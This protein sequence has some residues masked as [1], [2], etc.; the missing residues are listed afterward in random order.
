MPS[1]LIAVCGTVWLDIYIKIIV[2]CRDINHNLRKLLQFIGKN[3]IKFFILFIFLLTNTRSNL[4]YVYEILCQDLRT[5]A[6]YPLSVK[7]PLTLEK[8]D[9]SLQCPA[10]EKSEGLQKVTRLTVLSVCISSL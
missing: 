8:T 9:I 2:I 10:L 4:K 3:I 6:F 7:A 5:E 1:F